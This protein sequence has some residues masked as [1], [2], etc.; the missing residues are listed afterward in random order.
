MYNDTCG[1]LEM[2]F[3]FFLDF[4][5]YKEKPQPN[6]IFGIFFT[7]DHGKNEVK[8]KYACRQTVS[9]SIIDLTH[10]TYFSEFRHFRSQ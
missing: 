7:A 1:T 6:S 5:S 8:T 9:L 10:L 2:M 4:P 3:H